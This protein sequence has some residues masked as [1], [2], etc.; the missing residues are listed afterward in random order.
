[1]AEPTKARKGLA[2]ATVRRTR[3]WTREQGEWVVA[4]WERSG[5]SV[6][7]FAA[8]QELDLQ[9]VY[10][11]RKQSKPKPNRKRSDKARAKVVEVK[12]A[13][14]AAPLATQRMD[15][16]LV[17]GRRLSVAEQIDVDVLERVVA[18]LER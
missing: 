11:W 12:L 1:M 7:D 8:Q 9:R 14:T 3:R 18:M 2:W 16:E 13:P 15:I 10:F 17:S 6:K 4:Q 5:L